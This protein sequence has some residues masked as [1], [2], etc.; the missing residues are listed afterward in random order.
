V[1]EEGY[2]RIPIEEQVEVL[3]LVGNIALNDGEPKLH[4]RVVVQGGRH[5]ARWPSARGARAP[6]ARGDHH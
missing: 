4:M 3:A 6:D 5:R 1:A 2:T